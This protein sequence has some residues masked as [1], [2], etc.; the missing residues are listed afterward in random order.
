VSC[1]EHS[2]TDDGI[3][4]SWLEPATGLDAFIG[5][6]SHTFTLRL[7]VFLFAIA[8]GAGFIIGVSLVGAI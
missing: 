3:A 7:G 1:I 8:A 5:E 4:L 6:V 2:Q